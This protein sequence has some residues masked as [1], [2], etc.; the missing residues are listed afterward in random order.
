ML[1]S[2]KYSKQIDFHA[3]LQQRQMSSRKVKAKRNHNP[4][5]WNT[6]TSF[7][8]GRKSKAL[9]RPG[10][11]PGARDAEF[12][13][14]ARKGP[15]GC[16]K[17]PLTNQWAANTEKLLLLP[18]V[19]NALEWFFHWILKDCLGTGDVFQCAV[20]FFAETN[21]FEGNSEIALSLGMQTVQLH[22]SLQSL[23]HG[24]DM[25]GKSR[26]SLFLP[27]ACT[28]K[29]PNHT[30]SIV[31]EEQH[32][33][34]GAYNCLL[35]PAHSKNYFKRKAEAFFLLDGAVCLAAEWNVSYKQRYQFL[36]VPR[37]H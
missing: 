12:C 28:R 26:I 15:Q 32:S 2:N 3:Y 6:L 34:L 17:M 11:S 1:S 4:A 25:L 29:K 24:D 27:Q 5:A 31:L 22:V 18:S 23:W 21:Y 33:L 36:E 20:N 10:K 7:L 14:C 8:T 37:Q 19:R 35:L 16:A 30:S 13:T 9:H